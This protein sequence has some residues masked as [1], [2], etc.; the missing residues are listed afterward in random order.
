VRDVATVDF[1]FKDRDSF[2]RLDGNP[3]V[4]LDIIKR[5]GENIIETADAVKAAIERS[6]RRS[7][8]RHR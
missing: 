7:R 5:S 6:G 3:V 2:A 8:R 4:T 1:G